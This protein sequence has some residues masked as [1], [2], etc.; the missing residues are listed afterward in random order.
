MRTRIKYIVRARS[1]DERMVGRLLKSPSYDRPKTADEVS[2]FCYVYSVCWRSL[3]WAPISRQVWFW[4]L[5]RWLPLF[6]AT[7]S[8]GTRSC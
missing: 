4:L 6:S 5:S 3:K 1:Y 2:G 7:C 8:A